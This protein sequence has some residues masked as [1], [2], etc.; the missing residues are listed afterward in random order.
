MSGVWSST[1]YLQ[2]QPPASTP[3]PE[4][5]PL[6]QQ[7]CIDVIKGL[8]TPYTHFPFI[9]ILKP[10]TLKH[11]LLYEENI[12]SIFLFSDIPENMNN[13]ETEYYLIIRYFEKDYCFNNHPMSA[14]L[15]CFVFPNYILNSK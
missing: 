1:I 3:G 4:E 2:L 10:L 7:F 14:F 11:H 12:Q 15:F 9:H 8:N 13:Q 6:C 5:T